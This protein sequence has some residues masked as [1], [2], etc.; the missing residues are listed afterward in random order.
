MEN[1]LKIEMNK[2]RAKM[3]E[4]VYLCL[5]ILDI[6]KI[7]MYSYYYGY[8]KQKYRKI[9]QLRLMHREIFI[10]HVITEDINVD[11]PGNAKKRFD[12]HN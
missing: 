4:P 11:F 7:A 3:N 8:V 2:K 1:L 9:V 10:V 6:S 5:P 12:T